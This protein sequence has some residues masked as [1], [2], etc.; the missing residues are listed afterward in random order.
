MGTPSSEALSR[1]PC[2]ETGMELAGSPKG[3]QGAVCAC[4]R[5]CTGA[6]GAP[7]SLWGPLP[8]PG[9]PEPRLLRSGWT[10]RIRLCI[11]ASEGEF[12]PALSQPRLRGELSKGDPGG[13]RGPE[14]GLVCSPIVSAQPRRRGPR[15][16]HL[17]RVWAKAG[18]EGP[19]G[20]P[21]EDMW[22]EA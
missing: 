3:S 20:W 12:T 8:A 9:D 14:A 18:T 7:P 4:A 19:T 1:P 13:G 10:K 6:R 5:A 17:P 16:A 11:W 22:P 21:G 2:P 15:C